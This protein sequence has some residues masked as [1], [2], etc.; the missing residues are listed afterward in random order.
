MFLKSDQKKNCY[1][2]EHRNDFHIFNWV[3]RKN[4][5]LLFQK[6]FFYPV[7]SVIQVSHTHVLER[8]KQK[9]KHISR[10]K[11]NTSKLAFYSTAL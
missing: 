5:D 1:H 4:D 2:C 7:L 6:Y 9:Q 10:K 11:S 8:V 3:G